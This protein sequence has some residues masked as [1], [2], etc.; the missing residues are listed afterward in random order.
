MW[1]SCLRLYSA[2]AAGLAVLV[3]AE[4]YYTARYF[5]PPA[6]IALAAALGLAVFQG[7]LLCYGGYLALH[8][9]RQPQ[10]AWRGGGGGLSAGVRRLQRRSRIR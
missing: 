2:L 7:P 6:E 4:C 10:L 9:R 3:S 1:L 5:H 8:L